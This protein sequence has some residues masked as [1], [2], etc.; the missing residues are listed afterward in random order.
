MGCR[1]GWNMVETR[2]LVVKNEAC[3]CRKWA[4]C[5]SCWCLGS[6]EGGREGRRCAPLSYHRI[7]LI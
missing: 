1:N 6:K 7:S 2:L 3:N 4:F 5:P